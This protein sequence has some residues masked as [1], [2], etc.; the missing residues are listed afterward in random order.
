MSNLITKTTELAMAVTLTYISPGDTVVDATCGTGQDTIAL[1]EAVGKTGK[2]FAF[3]IQKKALILTESRLHAHGY[4]NVDFFMKSFESMG[5]HIPEGSA[6]AV[7][8]NLGYL[9]GG[10]HNLTT[11]ADAT[12]KGLEEALQAVRPGGIVTVVLYSGHAEGAAEKEQV[13]SWSRSLDPKKYHAAYVNFTNQPNN[14]PEILWIT[15]K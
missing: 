14:P 9:P 3:D 4:S 13:L 15:K 2:V 10:D 6:A 7:I 1:A 12:L 8:F 5:E 11:T